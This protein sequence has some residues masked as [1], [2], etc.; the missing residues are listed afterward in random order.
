[1]FCQKCGNE[2]AE[3]IVFCPRCGARQPVEVKTEKAVENAVRPSEETAEKPTLPTHSRKILRKAYEQL[4]ENTGLCPEI[5]SV[6]LKDSSSAV[7]AA[8]KYNNYTI[9]V[10]DNLI[11]LGS[12]PGI[13]LMIPVILCLVLYCGC[14]CFIDTAV[15]WGVWGLG[16]LSNLYGYYISAAIKKERKTVISFLKTA[17][18][19]PKY[20]EPSGRPEIII[21]SIFMFLGVIC[22]VLGIM[23][24]ITL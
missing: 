17:L 18:G 15:F 5:K 7:V 23:L 8:G 19:Q 11:S 24:S 1:M 4:R 14:F 12:L 20:I 3:N 2:L 6:V 9:S 16:M 21:C 22:M 13:S 10:L